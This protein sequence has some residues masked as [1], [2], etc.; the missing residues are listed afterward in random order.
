MLFGLTASPG[1]FPVARPQ[2]LAII[3]FRPTIFRKI[4]Q[5]ANWWPGR[6]RSPQLPT[7]E[8]R[9]RRRDSE[10]WGG[11]EPAGYSGDDRV[12]QEN[13]IPGMYHPLLQLKYHPWVFDGTL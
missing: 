3:R 10:V 9:N 4:L 6:R 11:H 2:W 5:L 1:I 13:W 7:V 8:F 12:V